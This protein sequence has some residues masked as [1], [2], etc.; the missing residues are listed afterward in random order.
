MD[1]PYPFG[2][3]VAAM[4]PDVIGIIPFYTIKFMEATRAPRDTFI[5][6]YSRLLLSN[7]FANTI[8]TTAYRAT[9]SLY[10]A[11]VF[12]LG[13]FVFLK[14]QWLVLSLSYLS[15]ILI[16]IPTHEG[17]FA[18]RIFFPSSDFHVQGVNWS[19]H[20]KR[21]FFFWVALGLIIFWLWQT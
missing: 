18:T 16:D 11:A 20:P 21:F 5:K 13:M 19:T 12:T 17:D 9:H 3:A 4:L 2:A 14:D 8:D 15:H 7:T 1:S 6:T 10:V